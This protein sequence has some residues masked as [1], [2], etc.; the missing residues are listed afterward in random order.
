MR[1][2]SVSLEADQSQSTPKSLQVYVFTIFILLVLSFTCW[3][4]YGSQPWS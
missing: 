4:L 3:Y 1:P 2:S